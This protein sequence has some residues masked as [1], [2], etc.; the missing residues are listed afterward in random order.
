MTDRHDK[1]NHA[2]PDEGFLYDDAG[3]P[4]EDDMVEEEAVTEQPRAARTR[5]PRMDMRHR[6]EERLEQR[7]LM[8]ELNEYEFFDLDDE[9][10]LH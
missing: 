9:S 2:T 4:D 6:I 3:F 5:K 7:R 1:Q 10:A 8:K